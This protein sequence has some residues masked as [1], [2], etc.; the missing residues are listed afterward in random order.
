MAKIILLWEDGGGGRTKW[1]DFNTLGRQIGQILIQG[2]KNR[3]TRVEML[4]E[5]Y[6]TALKTL[7][8]TRSPH[9]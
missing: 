4:L 2:T 5:S 3:G 7:R 9:F 8:A 6:S 1:S